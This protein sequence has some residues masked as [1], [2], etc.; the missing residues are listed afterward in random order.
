MFLDFEGS[1]PNLPT[2]GI[3]LLMGQCQPGLARDQLDT[4]CLLGIDL[5]WMTYIQTLLGKIPEIGQQSI[6]CLDDNE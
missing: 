6:I 3:M 2:I 1:T 5:H 4:K